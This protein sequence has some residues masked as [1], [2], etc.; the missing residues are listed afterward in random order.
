VDRSQPLIYPR[1]MTE[2]QKEATRLLNDKFAEKLKAGENIRLATVNDSGHLVLSAYIGTEQRSHTFELKT[3]TTTQDESDSL[4]LLLDFLDATLKEFFRLDRRA[5]F[6]LDYA[7]RVFEGKTL[8]VR[9]E[10]RDFEAERLAD[11]L[12]SADDAKKL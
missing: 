11:E 2:L 1:F 6:G 7:K 8:W 9:Q 12:L 10:F 3:Q 5:G 4:L